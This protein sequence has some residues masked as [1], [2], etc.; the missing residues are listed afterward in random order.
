[1]DTIYYKRRYNAITS[2]NTGS[3]MDRC[4]FTG[5]HPKAGYY[6]WETAGQKNG[7]GVAFPL[8]FRDETEV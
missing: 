7:N 3:N 8:A 5:I 2:Y 1:M 6:S 4:R